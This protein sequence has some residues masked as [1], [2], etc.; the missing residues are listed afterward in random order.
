M[1]DAIVWKY[2][3]DLEYEF[4]KHL[5]RGSSGWPTRGSNS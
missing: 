4:D 1:G 5:I 3:Q 2:D